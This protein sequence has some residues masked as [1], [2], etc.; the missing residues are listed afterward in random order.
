MPLLPAAVAVGL[1]G[2]KR[3]EVHGFVLD[4]GPQ[5]LGSEVE[6]SRTAIRD[7]RKVVHDLLA[8]AERQ[9]PQGGGSLELALEDVPGA[10]PGQEPRAVVRFGPGIADRLDA[11]DEIVEALGGDVEVEGVRAA[12]R[13]RGRVHLATNLLRPARVLERLGAV[14][15]I[16][17]DDERAV[18]VVEKLGDGFEKFPVA[19]AGQCLARNEVEGDDVDSAFDEGGKPGDLDAG[20]VEVAGR[21]ETTLPEAV[22]APGADSNASG[23]VRGIGLRRRADSQV[24]LL[25]PSGVL[26]GQRLRASLTLDLLEAEGVGGG[27]VKHLARGS[28]ASRVVVVEGRGVVS[29]VDFGDEGE[30]AE[31]SPLLLDR[32]GAGPGEVAL[33][34]H[35]AGVPRPPRRLGGVAGGR[36][37]S[38]GLGRSREQDQVGARQLGG[39]V[40]DVEQF[41][42]VGGALGDVDT[43]GLEPA[44]R[45]EVLL[46]TA[47]IIR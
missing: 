2:G 33:L 5:A 46:S 24:P 26:G 47:A 18:Q 32:R 29:A 12:G 15:E 1:S 35:Q 30:G 7:G 41:P 44:Q 40:V 6:A 14:L 17:S 20:S 13:I 37:S 31:R 19:D 16:P 8:R 3:E 43:K 9:G 4:G 45:R 22:V 11:D 34:P 39:E 23:E 10:V 21:S 38:D 42:H 25:S 28:P 36:W 27:P